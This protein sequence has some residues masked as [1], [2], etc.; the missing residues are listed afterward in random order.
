MPQ[1]AGRE[2]Q[3][4]KFV[5]LVSFIKLYGTVAIV[6]FYFIFLLLLLLLLQ[7]ATEILTSLPIPLLKSLLIKS[8]GTE[9]YYQKEK[10]AQ[11]SRLC[12]HITE[13]KLTRLSVEVWRISPSAGRDSL[14]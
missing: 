3:A 7:V 4:K 5:R 6:L 8:S 12:K 14:S 1:D 11:K 13:G 10:E 2:V 9:I